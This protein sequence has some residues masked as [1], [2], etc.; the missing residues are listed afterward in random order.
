MSSKSSRLSSFTEMLLPE[1]KV[2]LFGAKG[3]DPHDIQKEDRC[4]DVSRNSGGSFSI[5][6]SSEL[7]WDT[8]RVLVLPVPRLMVEDSPMAGQEVQ[9]SW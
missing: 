7:L 9:W 4:R 5:I 6:T 8:D 2:E 3:L 1:E